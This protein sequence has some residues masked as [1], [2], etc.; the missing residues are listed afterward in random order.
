MAG[1]GL[2]RGELDVLQTG[3]TEARIEVNMA[4]P[5]ELLPAQDW[6]RAQLE[7]SI[8]IATRSFLQRLFWT[9]QALTHYDLLGHQAIR[10][11]TTHHLRGSQR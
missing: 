2:L 6:E 11:P 3:P 8:E 9:L 7:Q 10:T 5:P 1:A 4:A